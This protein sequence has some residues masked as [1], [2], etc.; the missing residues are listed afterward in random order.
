MVLGTQSH[1]VVGEAIKKLNK[2]QLV[3]KHLCVPTE[4]ILRTQ[5]RSLGGISPLFQTRCSHQLFQY[6]KFVPL[7]GEN[8]SAR[9]R[10]PVPKDGSGNVHSEES[11]WTEKEKQAL[12]E[13]LR[14]WA[15]WEVNAKEG[16]VSSTHCEGV[17]KNNDLICDACHGVAR[18][19][20][21][22]RAVRKVC[23]ILAVDVN[24]AAD[25]FSRR[26]KSQN[27]HRSS[28]M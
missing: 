26:C 24:K 8:I 15:Q 22:K 2:P 5:T 20:S 14:A 17:T 10:V 9:P 21:F 27:S 16:Y 7:K 12:Y 11:L 23:L 28:S 4:Y 3:C 25:G 1:T 13:A 19:E 18:D 6:K